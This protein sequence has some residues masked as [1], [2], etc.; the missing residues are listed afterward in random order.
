MTAVACIGEC[1]I[2]LKQA[3]G[4]QAAGF[5]SRGFGGAR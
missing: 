5:Y 2:E 1:M 3:P 4:G